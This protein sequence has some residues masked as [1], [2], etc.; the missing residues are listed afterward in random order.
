[1]NG[2]LIDT[3]VIS[4]F[5]KLEPSPQVK[6]WFEAADPQ[7]LFVSVI[8]FGEIR[9]GLEDMPA[10]KRRMDLEKWFEEGLPEWFEANLLPITKPIVDRWAKLTVA[11]K[12]K[13][14]FSCD[15]GWIDSS[16][17]FSTWASACH[18]RREGLCWIRDSNC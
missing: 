2:P 14:Y 7:S 6:V 5:V 12:T 4:E 1:M 18:A 17:R 13:R 9:L 15:R 16:H 11:A 3:N 8:T 10:G